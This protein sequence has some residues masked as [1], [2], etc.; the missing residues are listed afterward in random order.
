MIILNVLQDASEIVPYN[1]PRIP[2]Y[3]GQ[4]KLSHYANMTSLC[5]W[6]EDVEYIHP[7]RGYMSYYV[8]GKKIIIKE[9]DALIINGRQMHYAASDDKT[10]C[11]FVGILF[12][13]G[14]LSKN[15]EIN[16]KYINPIVNQTHFP[17]FYLDSSDPEQAAIIE[18]FDDI[19]SVYEKK[20]T[21]YELIIFSILMNIW[22]KWFCLLKSALQDY[23]INI[24]DSLSIQKNMI[25]FIHQNYAS[26]LTLQDIARSG[27]V[28]RSKCCKIFKKYLHQT[29]MD[30]VNAYRLEVSLRLLLETSMTITEIAL[31]CGF[32]S[33][34]YYSEVFRRRKGC[35]PTEYRLHR[36]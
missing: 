9:K 18:L 22:V 15:P 33:P 1:N 5:H 28:C 29:P 16:E 17:Y 25:T 2:L 34:S 32:Q 7:V 20:D 26:R 31:S 3:I 10:D 36:Q 30:F 11:T 8:N 12:H 21:G 6:H 19:Y 4:S 23:Q 24:D 35:S 14:S 27:K 13:P